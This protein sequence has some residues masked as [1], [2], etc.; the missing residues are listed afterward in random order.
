M[1]KSDSWKYNP[2]YGYYEIK[3]PK[4]VTPEYQ[5]DLTMEIITDSKLSDRNKINVIADASDTIESNEKL[6]SA[7]SNL[8]T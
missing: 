6:L 7:A 4:I 8:T 5:S 1:N 3:L 2:N